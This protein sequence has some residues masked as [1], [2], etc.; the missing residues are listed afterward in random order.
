MSTLECDADLIGGIL[1]SRLEMP[2][3]VKKL[4][5]RDTS[6]GGSSSNISAFDFPKEHNSDLL[7]KYIT[8]RMCLQREGSLRLSLNLLAIGFETFSSNKNRLLYSYLLFPHFQVL[9][10]F[11]QPCDALLRLFHAL[12][13]FSFPL[14]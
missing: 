5:P 8:K 3:L 11:S 12:L 1:I 14:Q 7:R 9:L 13:S 6:A 4:L 10:L 2:I